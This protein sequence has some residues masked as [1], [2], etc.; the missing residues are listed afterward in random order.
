LREDG[1]DMDL[2]SSEEI[3]GALKYLKNNKAAGAD[4]IN[5]LNT[6]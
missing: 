3:V 5:A 1:V 2:P 4:S 6:N